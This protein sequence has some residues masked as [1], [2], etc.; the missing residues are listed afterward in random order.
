MLGSGA[1]DRLLAE[2][3]S[4]LFLLGSVGWFWLADVDFKYVFFSIVCCG[5]K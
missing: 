5:A 1:L 2:A 3:L 4:L